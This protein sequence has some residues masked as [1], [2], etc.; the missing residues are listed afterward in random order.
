MSNL[1]GRSGVR[2]GERSL[3]A[4]PRILLPIKRRVSSE[5]D[6]EDKEKF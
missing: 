2:R 6:D 3:V 5:R 4:R 1:G